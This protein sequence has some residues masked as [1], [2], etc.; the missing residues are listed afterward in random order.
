MSNTRRARMTVQREID[1]L[2][3]IYC[4]WCAELMEHSPGDLHAIGRVVAIREGWLTS[5][6]FPDK[7]EAPEVSAP[8]ASTNRIPSQRAH[9]GCKSERK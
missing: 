1:W 7:Q 2:A 4:P 6:S 5:E 3:G 9:G 8:E